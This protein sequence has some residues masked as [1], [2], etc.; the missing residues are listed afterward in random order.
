MADNTAKRIASKASILLRRRTAYNKVFKDTDIY[1]QIVL[2]D[3]R[4]FCPTDPTMA[5]AIKDD[6]DVF[7][8]IGRRQVLSRIMS[9]MNISD[10]KINEIAAA[11]LK[12][13]YNAEREW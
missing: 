13:R 3:L 4:H 5:G 7:I 10:E 6:K 9:M 8:N 1:S 2:T 12:E 11:E